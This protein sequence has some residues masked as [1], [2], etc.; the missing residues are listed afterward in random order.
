[1]LDN[2]H[3][4]PKNNF[5]FYEGYEDESEIVLC[6]EKDE[7]IHIWEGYFDDIFDSPSL[8]GKG[9]KGFTRDYHQLEGVFS[10]NGGV[11]EINPTE[12]LEDLMLYKE[13][14]FEFDET[15]EVFNLIKALLER[16]IK[17]GVTVKAQKV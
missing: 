14:T 10:E 15:K 1:M 3:W 4:K 5:T 13:K 6:I 9:W 2:G 11:Y 7:A 16:A 8:D 12:Y 17:E